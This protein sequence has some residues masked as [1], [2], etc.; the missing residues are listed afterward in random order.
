MLNM[1]EN[2]VTTFKKFSST[3]KRNYLKTK[4][5]YYTKLLK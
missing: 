4:Y 5:I 2:M 1:N 3:A